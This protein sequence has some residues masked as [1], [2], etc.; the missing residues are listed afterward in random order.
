V[1]MALSES[2][3]IPFSLKTILNFDFCFM[4]N[5]LLHNFVTDFYQTGDHDRTVEIY[6][7]N[8]NK[9]KY[10]YSICNYVSYIRVHYTVT[11]LTVSTYKIQSR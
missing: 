2:T 3:Q 7:K 8:F 5:Y 9:M 4:K 10:N 1:R 11:S 6:G